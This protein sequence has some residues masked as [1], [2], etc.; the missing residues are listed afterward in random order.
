[1][2]NEFVLEKL[3]NAF[4]SSI[5]E[6]TVEYDMLCVEIE[7]TALLDIVKY[8]Q[9]DAELGINFLTTLCTIHYPEKAGK[10]FMMMYQF[11]SMEKNY[12]IRLKAALSKDN[13][14]IASLTPLYNG[15][16]WQERQ[17]FDFFGVHFEGHPNLKRILNMDEMDYFPMRKEYRLE[18]AT[19]TDKDDSFFG[20]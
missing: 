6:H 8:L 10:E 1:M 9:T 16:N 7:K 11:Q 17:E 2:T 4:S 14:S 5:V 13:I 12:R 15:A 19:R 3:Q 18:D 20:R